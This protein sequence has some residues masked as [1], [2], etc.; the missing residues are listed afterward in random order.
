MPQNATLTARQLITSQ[1]PALRLGGDLPLASLPLLPAYL[2]PAPT[3]LY[4]HLLA[5]NQCMCTDLQP[6]LMPCCSLFPIWQVYSAMVTHRYGEI[7]L[8]F[9]KRERQRKKMPSSFCKK[10][11]YSEGGDLYHGTASDFHQLFPSLP[12]S[13]S[14]WGVP[15]GLSGHRDVCWPAQ[16]QCW[17]WREM[18]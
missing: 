13:V 1:Q 7:C 5:T 4:H 17:R 9:T 8:H 11:Q 14:L 3:T 16:G 2:L 18:P 6:Q 12:P 15:K 10:N